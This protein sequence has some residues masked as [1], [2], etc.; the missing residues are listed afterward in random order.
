MQA[1]NTVD[2]G[3]QLHYSSASGY[4]EFVVPITPF[5]GEGY[6]LFLVPSRD[7][8]VVSANIDFPPL[9]VINETV[10]TFIETNLAFPR[11]SYRNPAAVTPYLACYPEIEDF[12]EAA[13]PALVEYFD[14]SIEIVLEVLTYPGDETIHEELV[15]WIQSSNDVDEGLAKLE[16]FED[17]WYLDHMAEVGH[18]FNFNI[19]TR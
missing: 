3:E 17:E 5:V 8:F 19:E 4:T 7:T 6:S 15:G 12:I 16:R 2:I 14:D 11:V 10:P 13:W 18:N 1:L 9:D